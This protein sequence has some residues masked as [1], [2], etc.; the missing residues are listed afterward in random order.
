MTKQIVTLIVSSL[1]LILGGIY[2]IKYIE[3][4]SRYLL[5]D[6]NYSKNAIMN[7]NFEL[8]KTSTNNIEKTWKNLRCIWN[9]F[10][11]Q[12]EIDDVD[13][14]ISSFKIHTRYENKEESIADCEVLE[15]MINDIV[16]KHKI[17]YENIF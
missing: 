5:S 8:A 3:N 6:I 9:I 16:E 12:D 13:N 10:V 17:K 11:V 14:T 15:K 7:N 4:S 2:E 1:L